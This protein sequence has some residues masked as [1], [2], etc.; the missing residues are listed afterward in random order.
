[1]RI[2]GLLTPGKLTPLH[3]PVVPWDSG[4]GLIAF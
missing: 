2:I 1:L 3:F 4:P